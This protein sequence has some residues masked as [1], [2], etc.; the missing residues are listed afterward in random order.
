L[1]LEEHGR[2]LVRDRFQG[3]DGVRRKVVEMSVQIMLKEL[4]PNLWKFDLERCVH[5]GHI[6]EM[7]PGTG[8]CPARR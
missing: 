4:G 2:R 3:V 1:L 6:L 7:D 5:C 8:S